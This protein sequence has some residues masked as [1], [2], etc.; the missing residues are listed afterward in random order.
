[1]RR[2]AGR[3]ARPKD[4]A[5]ILERNQHRR[6]F[7]ADFIPRDHEK[8][9]RPSHSMVDTIGHAIRHLRN[10]ER[11]GVQSRILG[12]HTGK[13]AQRVFESVSRSLWT[14]GRSFLL[15]EK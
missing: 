14:C 7:T 9:R 6:E 2:P 13:R 3:S 8:H 11:R 15:F 10:R 4:W 5:A 12:L 1:M